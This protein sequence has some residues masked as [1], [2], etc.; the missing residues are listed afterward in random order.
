MSAQNRL[1]T[2]CLFRV[3]TLVMIM[4]LGLMT[5]CENPITGYGPQPVYL[6]KQEHRPML[7]VFGVLRPGT[8][9]GMPLSFVHLE[10]SFSVTSYP[11][12]IEV[13]DADVTLF[14]YEWD[15]IVDSMSFMYTHFDSTFQRSEYRHAEFYP[16]ENQTYGISCCKSGFPELTSKT[17]VPS[18]PAIIEDSIEIN[19]NRL[20]FSILGDSLAALYDITLWVG[21]DLYN[22]RLRRPEVGN[23]D[24]AFD[25][26]TNH[27][28]SGVLLVYAYDLQLS[29]YMT[30]N[31]NVKY[32]SYRS[33]YSTVENG[34]GCF[35]SLNVLE[36]I[37]TF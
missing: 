11:D 20:T 36:R 29:K 12:T 26:D 8:Q 25:L 3:V 33:D 27:G 23:I 32:N 16:V 37:V 34:L 28:P 4:V 13:R 30:Y 18:V 19:T 24:V 9:N 31:V 14:R 17:T 35:G 7:N 15:V 2:V 21:E 5:G 1:R 6:D 22:Q 10:E